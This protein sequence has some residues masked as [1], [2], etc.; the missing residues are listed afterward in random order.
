[1]KGINKQ[2]VVSNNYLNKWSTPGYWQGT[3][4]NKVPSFFV[5]SAK[6]QRTVQVLD[7]PDLP[8]TEARGKANPFVHDR[9]G[10]YGSSGGQNRRCG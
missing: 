10:V 4:N 9:G 3:A 6:K 1:M 2:K 7:L 8:K 5:V